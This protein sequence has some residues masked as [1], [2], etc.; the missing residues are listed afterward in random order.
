MYIPKRCSFCGKEIRLG[1]GILFVRNDGSTRPYC[2]SKCK[3]NDTKLGR[4]P[5][6]FKWARR[7]RAQ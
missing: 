6:K 4:D 1:L 5:R 2:S 7:N 3:I